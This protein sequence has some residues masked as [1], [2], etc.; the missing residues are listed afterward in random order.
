[1]RVT[2]QSF[3]EQR[4]RLSP[5]TWGGAMRQGEALLFESG[6]KKRVALKAKRAPTE[7]EKREQKIKA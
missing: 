2:L 7:K 3:I 5:I 4:S 1:M 6:P